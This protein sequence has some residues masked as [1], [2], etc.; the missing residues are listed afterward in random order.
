MEE[1]TKGINK[2]M[3]RD[4]A[5][6]LPDVTDEMYNQ[7]NQETREMIQE[8]FD[9]KS[10]LSKDTKTQYKS[11]LRQFAYWLHEN[12]NDKP[13]YKIKKRDFSRFM[14]YLVNRGMSSSGL[15]FK[16]SA[17]SSL[18]GYILDYIVDDEDFE[19]YSRFR[20][21]TTVFKIEA[22]NYVY[23]KIPVSEEEYNK[24]KEA[25][26]DDENYEALAWVACA[27]N[28]GARRGGIRQFKVECIKDGIPEGKNYVFSNVVREKG[29]GSDG[30][31]VKYMINKECIDYINLWLEHRGYEHEY[32]FTTNYGGEY[33]MISR[34]WANDLCTNVLSDIL[35]R[36][37]NPHLFKA[38]AITNLLEHGKS[39]KTV[40]KYVAQHNSIETTSKF[41]DLRQDEDID[42]LFD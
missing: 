3:V 42:D 40:S 12:C 28:C 1:N 18:C 33:H 29:K 21:F 25:L 31:R 10:Q 16:K 35:G 38:S 34:E 30:K 24:L 32:I 20:N 39:M 9:N 5:L 15:K 14:S 22:L 2:N 11:A 37:I 26:L 4:R 36:R 6:R 27:F 23:E 19:E 7:C 8:F 13:L 41:Y 17:I